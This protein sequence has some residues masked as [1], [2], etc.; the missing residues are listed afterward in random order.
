MIERTAVQETG[1]HLASASV[2]TPQSERVLNEDIRASAATDSPL[3]S[4]TLAD[5][6]PMSRPRAGKPTDGDTS[7]SSTVSGHNPL[8]TNLKWAAKTDASCRPCPVA[9]MS[10]CILS[11]PKGG[12]SGTFVG[13]DRRARS[14]PPTRRTVFPKS[15]RSSGQRLL[16]RNLVASEWKLENA[17]PAA[18]MAFAWSS[19]DDRG[20]RGGSGICLSLWLFLYRNFLTS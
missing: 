19:R 11:N 8:M 16:A 10:S 3:F 5:N 14:T 20:S 7:W 6:L 1:R 18:T 4:D 17:D 13:F 2:S 15:A 9:M 12:V